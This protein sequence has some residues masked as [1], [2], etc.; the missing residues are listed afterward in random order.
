MKSSLYGAGAEYALHSLLVMVARPE[1]V[2]VRDLARFQELPERYLAKLF[3]RLRRAGIVEGTE[4]ISGG[5]SL[6]RP[7]AAI[8][9]RDILEAVDPQR[10]LFECGEIRRQC[11]L[12]AGEPPAWSTR[13]TCR[14]HHFMQEAEAV[15]FDFLGSKSLADLAREFEHKAPRRFISESDLWFRD[16]R[17]ERAARKQAGS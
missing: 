16:S 7:P 2:S 10:S 11:A 15:L 4:G 9:V 6:A 5:F 8:T 14:I 3:T 12:F 17:A 1:P 13:G